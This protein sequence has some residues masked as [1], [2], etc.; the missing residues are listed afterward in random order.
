MAGSNDRYTNINGNQ[1]LMMFSRGVKCCLMNSLSADNFE[2]R[3][4]Y[5]IIDWAKKVTARTCT[6]SI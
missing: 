2:Y 3:T 1:F 5:S 4:V 6:A